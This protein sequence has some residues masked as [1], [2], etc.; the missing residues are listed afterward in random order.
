MKTMKNMNE[1][2]AT[3]EDKL[4]QMKAR[5]QRTEDKR[6]RL[7]ARKSKKDEQRRR[8]LVGAIVLGKV[9]RG[10][11]AQKDVRE[12]LDTEL[13]RPVDRALFDL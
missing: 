3:L 12:W 2:I 13:E 5:Q 6:K 10:E 7:E 11:L 1:R 9:Q 8:L 4:R